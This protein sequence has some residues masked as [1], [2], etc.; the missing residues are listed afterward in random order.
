MPDHFAV[1]PMPVHTV[2]MC[3]HAHNSK[4]YIVPT[5][6]EDS[7]GPLESRQAAFKDSQMTPIGWTIK[8]RPIHIA[9]YA[10]DITYI[11]T[12]TCTAS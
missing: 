6:C 12:H 10:M 2:Y 3:I 1:R 4:V 11:R 8:V 5:G 7:F 9:L